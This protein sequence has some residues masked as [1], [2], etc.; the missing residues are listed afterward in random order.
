LDFEVERKLTAR[1]AAVAAVSNAAKRS[2]PTL[3]H[4][5]IE[6]DLMKMM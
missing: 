1:S 4:I 5:D 6:D 3:E 2:S